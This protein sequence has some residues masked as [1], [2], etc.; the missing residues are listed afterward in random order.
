MRRLLLI[1]IGSGDPDDV[2]VR[3]VRALAAVEV[4]FVIDK[5]LDKADLSGLRR[6]ICRRHIP[7][8]RYRIVEIADPERDRAAAAY[9]SAV[10]D[11]R[12]QRGERLE[13]AIL[14][15]LPED[16]CGGLL[17]W[18]DPSLYDSTIDVVERMLAKGRVQL[19]YEVIPGI[20]SVQVLA[21]RH[22]IP[23]NRV[24]GQVLITTGR[25]LRAALSAD[26]SHAALPDGDSDAGLSP[27]DSGAAPADGGSTA[28]LPPG[29]DDVVVM[30]DS[31]CSFRMLAGEDVDIY[32]GAFLGTEEE[33]LVSGPVAEVAEEIQR[34]REQARERK[35]WIM[36]T[37]LLRRR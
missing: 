24:G 1:G 32:W 16:G 12:E 9:G 17:V 2:T 35:G 25:R 7:H 29:F 22:R 30:L 6:E 33:I 37:Y 21:A 15:E 11:W 8:G 36:D 31:E 23:L 20:S 14:R 19:D 3:A 28:A 27:G 18:G 4:F 5:G 10:E 26:G 13:Q 34:V